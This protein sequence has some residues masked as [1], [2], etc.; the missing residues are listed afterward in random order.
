MTQ[1]AIAQKKAI[2]HIEWSIAARLPVPTDAVEQPGLAGAVAGVHNEMLIVAGGANFPN[3]MPW[4][5]GKKEYHDEVYLFKK[6]AQGKLESLENNY[7]LPF[8]TAYGSSCST[9]HGVVYIGG[10]SKK[11]ISNK[12][13][14][15]QWNEQ[16]ESLIIKDLPHLQFAVT[17][18][19]VSSSGDRI[20]VAGG[21]TPD[22]VSTAFQVLDL[23]NTLSGW[24]TLPS[25]PKPVSHAVSV[26]QTSKGRTCLYLIG[27]RKK[28]EGNVSDLYNSVYE[29]D[30]KTS[31]WSEKK[32]LPYNLSAGTGA[33]VGNKYILMFGGD[34]GET[35]NK[36]ERLIV[37]I[38]R[39]ADDKKKS[40]LNQQKI[41]LQSNHPGFSKDV[42]QYNV[43]S[44]Q[45]SVIGSAPFDIPVT[46]N[47]IKC[48]NAVII[49]SGEIKAG[50]R[51]PEILVGK[52]KYR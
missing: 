48:K 39:A 20:F 28:N 1:V 27:G 35:F 47:A 13:L 50:I 6:G 30:L 17:N 31:Q 49:P 16:T 11:G 43:V 19:S 7:K 42:L 33:A 24:K 25:L 3:G 23:A 32:P 44:D 38:S 9:P 8:A 51:T 21:E 15:I 36:T 5:G 45:W 40:E 22:S 41:S 18:A 10:E 4:L 26:V 29:F 14:L 37:D 34:R 2:D 52:I 46:T 12:V